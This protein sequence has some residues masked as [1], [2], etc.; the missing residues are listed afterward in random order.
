M[1][2]DRNLLSSHPSLATNA[3]VSSLDHDEQ[4]SQT[5]QQR[6]AQDRRPREEGATWH[7]GHKTAQSCPRRKVLQREKKK[8]RTRRAT[9]HT[10]ELRKPETKCGLETTH[11]APL[12]LEA[13]REEKGVKI[14]WSQSTRSGNP[15]V[16]LASISCRKLDTTTRS[17]ARRQFP[18]RNNTTAHAALQTTP[19]PV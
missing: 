11:R 6:P 17:S 4:P 14:S 2:P 10:R 19:V 9:N 1:R 3:E 8:G 16:S 7:I 12:R 13:Y 15:G 5:L 18:Q